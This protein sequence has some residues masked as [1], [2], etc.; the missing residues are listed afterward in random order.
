MY[1]QSSTPTTTPS[2]L[3][4]RARVIA[5]R[6]AQ[7]HGQAS[8]EDLYAAADAYI[9]ALRQYKRRTGRRLTIPNRAYLLRAL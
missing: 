8:I 9:A 1:P 5:V 7:Q 6:G 4:L 3:D 2:L